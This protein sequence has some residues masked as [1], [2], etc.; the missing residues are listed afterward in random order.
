MKGIYFFSPDSKVSPDEII[1]TKEHVDNL[2]KFKNN[3]VEEPQAGDNPW[4]CI[5]LLTK[6]TAKKKEWAFWDLG[7]IVLIG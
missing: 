7:M 6:D 5:M 1:A 2:H 3:K 4:Q